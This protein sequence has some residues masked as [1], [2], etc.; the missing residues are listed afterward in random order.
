MA[1]EMLKA[2]PHDERL[3]K[4]MAAT[5]YLAGSDT[6]VSAVTSFFLAMVVYPE[7]QK[8]AQE[9]LERVVRRDRFP[10]FSDKARLPY[11]EGVIRECLRWLPVV[12]VGK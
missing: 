7:V 12:P 5:V 8:R 1:A 10:D 2:Y 6:T 4:E 9:E 11:L 3:V